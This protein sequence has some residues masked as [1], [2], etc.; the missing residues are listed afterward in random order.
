MLSSTEAYG[1]K[2]LY[3]T[4]DTG[5]GAC[6]RDYGEFARPEIDLICDLLAPFGKDATF[7]DVGANIG[8]IALPVAKRVGCRV[9]ALEGNGPIFDVLATNA[10][11]NR[12][13]NI[14]PVHAVVEDADGITQFP[15]ALMRNEGN[16]GAWNRDVPADIPRRE[17]RQCRI[18]S[19]A[20]PNTRLIKMDL[21]GAEVAALVGAADT[22]CNLRPIVLIEVRMKPCPDTDRIIR[23]LA[24]LRYG[25]RWFP[26]LFTT[27][28]APKKPQRHV[29]WDRM[30]L[31]LPKRGLLHGWDELERIDP[32]NPWANAHR[33][34]HLFKYAQH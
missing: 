18:D 15:F 4:G 3:P 5:V 17:V 25:L 13:A 12:L 6:L 29:K 22:I 10:R 1:L 27:P 32:N 19:I 11:D 23:S 8:A 9:I 16:Y 24:A 28:A 20:P 2:F 31:A 30:I 34:P 14:E 33:L 26:S 7:I 21:D